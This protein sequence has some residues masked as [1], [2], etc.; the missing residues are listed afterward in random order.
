M[1]EKKTAGPKSTDEKITGEAVEEKQSSG[2][3]TSPEGI[4]MLSAAG[5]IDIV[6]IIP[7]INILS[8]VLGIII[9]GGW[10][11]ITRPGEALKKAVKRLLVAFG[12]ELIPVVSIAPTW[13]WFV[14]KTLKS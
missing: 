10:L 14:Y 5:I 8:D 7:G 13:T 1:P 2:G 12:I 11:V 9:I 3:L 6:S 4:L